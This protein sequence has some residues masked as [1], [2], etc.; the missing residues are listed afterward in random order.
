M[1]KRTQ[2]QITIVF[3]LSFIIISF[4]LYQNKFLVNMFILFIVFVTFYMIVIGFFKKDKAF[5]EANHNSDNYRDDLENK[6]LERTRKLNYL[7]KKLQTSVGDLS[8]T[9]KEL[10]AA[11]KMASLGE[12]VSSVTHEISS[13]LGVS[14]SASSHLN[15]LASEL[16]SSYEKELMSQDEFE[17]FLR[18]V[19]ELSEILTLNLTNTK[20]LV[21]SFKNIA[22]DQALADIRVFNVKDYILEILLAVNGITK[23]TKI[24]L[25]FSCDD[26]VLIKSYPGFFSQ[27]LTNFINNSVL[28]GFN[29]NEEGEIHIS[30]F[31]ANKNIKLVYSDNGKGIKEENKE[32]IFEQ[33]FT[34]RK[35]DGGTGLGLHIIKQ[36]INEELHGSI[37]LNKTEKGVEFLII[38]PKNI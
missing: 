38:I 20:N 1:Y 3:I 24:Q 25:L 13:P 23:N 19:K 33:Y 16:I 6:V 37:R 10:I 18:K 34:T 12:L 35:G 11:E 28:H 2:K 31:N 4:V 26:D 36:I 27:I 17:N 29:E 5:N 8:E 22:V 9:K 7:N 21:G 14:I 32:K 15:H 30:V